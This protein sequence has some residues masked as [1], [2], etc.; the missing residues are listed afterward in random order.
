MTY[1]KKNLT[2]KKNEMGQWEAHYEDFLIESS[3]ANRKADCEALA[4]KWVEMVNEMAEPVIEEHEVEEPE[5]EESQE[6]GTGD[7]VKIRTEETLA[8]VVM[9]IQE[10][11]G[12]WWYEV[13]AIGIGNTIHR[14]VKQ[15]DLTL[16]DIEEVQAVESD[17]EPYNFNH[18][19]DEVLDALRNGDELKIMTAD[20][21]FL[22]RMTDN[23]MFSIT[24]AESGETKVVKF[25]KFYGIAIR[26]AFGLATNKAHVRK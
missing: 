21:I 11:D 4:K 12:S 20:I 26:D 18:K 9:P 13:E 16:A 8:K 24:E 3:I 7:I 10:E 19:L 14:E 5:V 17:E 2:Y 22:C 25:P 1:L 15:S 23:G 6:F